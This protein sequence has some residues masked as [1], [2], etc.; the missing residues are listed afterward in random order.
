MKK[1]GASL[2]DVGRESL[3]ELYNNLKESVELIIMMTSFMCTSGT[4][5]DTHAAGPTLFR[6]YDH[7]KNSVSF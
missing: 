1:V 2:L 7:A 4:F 5:D 6:S 3:F